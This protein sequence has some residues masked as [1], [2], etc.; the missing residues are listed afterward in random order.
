MAL[1]RIAVDGDCNGGTCPAVHTTENPDVLV[2]QGTVL[3]EVRRSE[4][5]AIPSTEDAVTI[6]TEVIL[7][8]ARL[9]EGR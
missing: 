1:I 8:A 9:I 6:P 3:D 2:I 5:G 4:L 7:R